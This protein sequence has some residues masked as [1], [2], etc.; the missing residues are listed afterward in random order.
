MRLQRGELPERVLPAP[1]GLQAAERDTRGGGGLV[2]HRYVCD[3]D[4]SLNLWMDSQPQNHVLLFF[5]YLQIIIQ[6][7]YWLDKPV[8]LCAKRTL[9]LVYVLLH[10]RSFLEEKIYHEGVGRFYF[11]K[12][13]FLLKVLQLAP[14]PSTLSP[15]PL[16]RSLSRPSP[17]CDIGRFNTCY[18]MKCRQLTNIIKNL[19]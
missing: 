8:F 13:V 11:L 6:T 2:R 9:F 19:D 4:D 1:G 10:L 16:S 17:H 12:L 15:T 7:M 3:P 14:F 5:C 18:L